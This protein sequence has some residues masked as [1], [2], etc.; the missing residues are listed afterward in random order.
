VVI[1][2]MMERSHMNEIFNAV[3][4]NLGFGYCFLIQDH[5]CATFGAGTPCA[6]VVDVGDQKVSVSC[7]D[8]GVSFPQSRVCF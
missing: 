3:V 8:D 1:P 6:T 5:I 7:V 4:N 2:V